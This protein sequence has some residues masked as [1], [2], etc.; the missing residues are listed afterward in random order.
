MLEIV[1]TYSKQNSVSKNAS[2][3]RRNEKS[4]ARVVRCKNGNRLEITPEIVEILGLEDSVR[5]G[6]S[7][8]A[9]VLTK[10]GQLVENKFDLRGSGKTKY[11]YSKTLVNEIVDTLGLDMEGRT[12]CSLYGWHIEDEEQKYLLVYQE[13]CEYEEPVSEHE[14]M[15]ELG[16]ISSE[17]DENE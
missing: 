12:S 13:I 10:D 8:N 6:F 15:I 11:V 4:I 3:R 5:I 2:T 14:W 1:Q 17:E 16:L 7:S 9:I